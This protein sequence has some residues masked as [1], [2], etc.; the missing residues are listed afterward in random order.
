[1]ALVGEVLR[2]FELHPCFFE[3][4]NS[5]SSRDP[6]YPFAHQLELMAKLFPRRPVRVL[7]G[8]EIG[9]GKTVTAAMILKYLLE[10]GGAKRALVLLP[11]VLVQQWKGELERFGFRPV[12]QLERDTIEKYAGEGF[13][14]GVYI[15][16]IDLVKREKYSGRL[17]SV[18]W[19]VTVVDEAH[20]IGKAGGRETQRYEFVKRLVARPEVNVLFLTATP[21]RGTAED[22]L[23]RIMLLDPYLYASVKEL[24][25]KEFYRRVLNTLVYRRTKRDV[26]EVYEGRKVFTDCRFTA[27]V[28]DVSSEERE[29][30]ERLLKFLRNKLSEYY[31]GTRQQPRAL[32]LLMT[33]IAKRASSSPRAAVLTLN[34]I[35]AKRAAALGG[36]VDSQKLERKA[37]ELAS[38]L[39][40][41]S[42]EDAGL[43]A[44]E[45]IGGVEPDSALNDFAEDCSALLSEG[46]ISELKRL[47]ELA[48][49]T[50]GEK[51]SRLNTVA[52]LVK[53]RL[54][55]GDKV[56][57]FTEYIDTAVYVYEELVR[58]LRGCEDRIA[59]VTSE[60]I[61]PPSAAHWRGGR[62]TVEDVKT[63]LR[64]GLVD[65]VVS[66]DFASEGLNLQYANVVIHY[67]PTWSPVK[68]VQRIGRVWRLGQSKDVHSYS[69]LLAVESDRSVFDILYAKLLSWLISGVEREAIAGEMLEIDMPP[70]EGSPVLSVPP[71]SRKGEQ[72]Y[73]EYRALL[74]FLEK[75]REGLRKYVE[76]VLAALKKLKEEAEKA[77]LEAA[78]DKNQVKMFIDDVLGSLSGREAEEALRDILTTILEL[79]G[80]RVEVRDDRVYAGSKYVGLRAPNEL[81]VVLER[82]SSEGGKV[83]SV[84]FVRSRA[85]GEGKILYLY[86]VNVAVGGRPCHSEVAGFLVRDAGSEELLRGSRLLKLLA[87]ALREI[88]GFADQVRGLSNEGAEKLKMFYLSSYPERT[89]HKFVDYMANVERSLSGKHEKWRPRGLDDVRVTTTFITA[90]VELGEGGFGPPPRLVE[91]VERK[92]IEFAM[93]FER[94]QGRVPEDVSK[95]EHYDIRSVEPTTGEVRFIEVKGAWGFGVSVELTRDEFELAKKLADRHW[96][97][98][99]LGISTGKPVL[100]AVRDPAHRLGWLPEVKSYR[101]AQQGAGPGFA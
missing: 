67:E 17:L 55:G 33:L 73:S 8:D 98:V 42:F 95:Y 53:E 78:S 57:I 74:E 87:R 97:Y 76:H 34:R 7:I 26:N 13:P 56:V 5:A 21:H 25:N 71:P 58:R 46:D 85:L 16:S 80:Y 38:S 43:Y 19:D 94:E 36:V 62:P 83:P 32:P 96:L 18:R 30:H 9:L 29:F 48:R 69:I 66:T 82:E 28:S 93:E 31:D 54:R 81:Y 68:I 52:K 20:R 100:L 44:D 15:A 4:K 23:E 11:R 10:V 63:W 60:E 64:E 79:R 72:Q 101:L 1:M 3:L 41:F 89:F 90:L 14:E 22:Y 37:E 84:L 49:K 39:L 45:E 59:L 91:E 6:V 75:G 61:R 65:V 27:R 47:Y 86:R 77:G 2:G 92:A 51:D 99:V 88:V 35:I 12:Y 50:I 40:S 24:D 70:R